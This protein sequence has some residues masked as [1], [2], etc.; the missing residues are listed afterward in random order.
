MAYTANDWRDRV[1]SVAN[2]LL[3]AE[4]EEAAMQIE[5]LERCKRLA[6]SE[7]SRERFDRN[8]RRIEGRVKQLVVAQDEAA[9][10]QGGW[11]RML[12][13]ALDR[14]AHG[15]QKGCHVTASTPEAPTHHALMPCYAKEL[16]ALGDVCGCPKCMA[17]RGWMDEHKEASRKQ[18]EALIEAARAAGDPILLNLERARDA[19]LRRWLSAHGFDC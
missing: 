8:V 13:M 9:P 10:V 4:Q 15:A 11:E 2:A 6:T 1:N 18:R 5:A 19:L 12:E 16:K 14:A 3:M 17:H 7:E